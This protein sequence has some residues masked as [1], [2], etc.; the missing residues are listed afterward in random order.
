[1]KAFTTLLASTLTVLS[2]TA[3]QA[4]VQ[5]SQPFTLSS[6]VEVA[7]TIEAPLAELTYEAPAVT[8]IEAPVVAEP[9][10]EAPAAITVEAA[11]PTA[12]APVVAEP[13]VEAP[14]PTAPTA[15]APVVAEPVV[16]VLAAATVEPVADYW[17]PSV[18]VRMALFQGDAQEAMALFNTNRG[19]ESL[20]LSERQELF[21]AYR[22]VYMTGYAP[23]DTLVIVSALNPT[24]CYAFS[25]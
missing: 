13:V 1:M 23:A 6:Q 20:P 9:I 7:Q 8:T 22:G 21:S 25:R 24:T 12:V 18:G 17:E 19:I 3:F 10:V 16:E 11:A 2:L 15:A 14:A 4:P 5:A